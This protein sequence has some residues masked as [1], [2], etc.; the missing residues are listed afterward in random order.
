MQED[1]LTLDDADYVRG[2]FFFLVDPSQID[3]Y[4]HVDALELDPGLGTR[5]R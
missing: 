3:E 1:T 2:Q 5:P 4:P